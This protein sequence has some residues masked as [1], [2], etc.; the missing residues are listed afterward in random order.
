MLNQ[1]Y[2]FWQAQLAT[3]QGSGD[4][5]V[6][7]RQQIREKIYEIEKQGA[8]K[9]QATYMAQAEYELS[10]IKNDGAAKVAKVKEIADEVAAVYGASDAKAIEWQRKLSDAE[11]AAAEESKEI[12]AKKLQDLAAHNERLL[13]EQMRA[14]TSQKNLGRITEA[15]LLAID[16]DIANKRLAIAQDLAAKLTAIWAGN[17]KKIEEI[18]KTLEKATDQTAQMIQKDQEQA[19]QKTYTE[20]KQAMSQV[21]SAFDSAIMGM[22]NKSEGFHKSLAKI[23]DSIVSTFVSFEV[24]RMT[25]SWAD[26]LTKM[27]SDSN[28]FATVQKG[29][30]TLLGINATST[31]ATTTAAQK[32]EAAQVIPAEA[33]V[34]A[35]GAAASVA[36]IPY[37]GPAMAAAAYAQTMSMVM[38]GMGVAAAES[39]AWDIPRTGLAILHPHE[40]VLPASAAGAFRNMANGGGGNTNNIN[41][42][43]MDS[44]SV[45]SALMN[46]GVLLRALQQL[47]RS[48]AFS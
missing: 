7:L 30:D 46:G 12:Q 1:E 37:V 24:K 38:G 25:T 48:G 16:I 29:I 3:V 44:S 10:L 32:A 34:A 20:W 23:F 31:A 14:A 22:L 13:D 47:Q 15:Q 2:S 28:V 27:T 43:A 18:D 36:S 33:A 6:K 8:E 11:R 39:G 40:T 35:G 42:T 4:A 26:G 19:A 9:G 45:Y 5:Q 21:T 41:V 17:E